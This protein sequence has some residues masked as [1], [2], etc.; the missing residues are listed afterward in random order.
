MPDLEALT[1]LASMIDSYTHTQGHLSTTT[2]KTDRALVRSLQD[3]CVFA[4][5]FSCCFI[6]YDGAMLQWCTGAKRMVMHEYVGSR[7]RKQD[8][9][10]NHSIMRSFHFLT[11]ARS[12]IVNVRAH[13]RQCLIMRTKASF[14]R[15][16]PGSCGMGLC[17]C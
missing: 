3:R 11:C 1:A 6:A 12:W 10:H 2:T 7:A 17:E 5:P 8:H 13:K 16:I 15:T 4:F 9:A 14:T